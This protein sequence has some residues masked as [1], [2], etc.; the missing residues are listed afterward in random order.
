MFE[1]NLVTTVVLVSF[2]SSIFN[3][4]MAI[5]RTAVFLILHRNQADTL[6]TITLEWTKKALQIRPENDGDLN[7]FSR[8]GRRHLLA[9]TLSKIHVSNDQPLKFEILSSEERSSSCVLYGVYVSEKNTG[10]RSLQRASS[11]GDLFARFLEKEEEIKGAVMTAFGLDVDFVDHFKF[12]VAIARTL[13]VSPEEQIAMA[14]DT[15][16]YFAVSP[17]VLSDVQKE[18]EEG[19]AAMEAA[20]HVDSEEGGMEIVY[21]N[22]TRGG[23]TVYHL[24]LSI[25]VSIALNIISCLRRRTS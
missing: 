12:D 7:P 11:G 17:R 1:L 18:M 2:I 4:L 9:E 19:M 5:M 8:C 3:I 20:E 22:G 10:S 23:T 13:K 6:F 15:M 24:S 14:I 21:G 16:R 25:Q